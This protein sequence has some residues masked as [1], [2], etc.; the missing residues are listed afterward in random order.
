MIR[1]FRRKDASRNRQTGA[2][3]DG[4]GAENVET[5]YRDEGYRVNFHPG[6]S[7]V[8]I[9]AFGGVGLAMG[10]IQIDEFRNTL[11]GKHNVYFLND[12]KRSWWNN[13][14]IEDV[15]GDVVESGRQ[16]GVTRWSAIGNS[17][18]GSG[19]MLASVLVEDIERVLAYSPQANVHVDF[20]QEIRWMD[21]RRQISAFRWENY[22]RARPGCQ[23]N[24]VFG[25]KDDDCHK[26]VFDTNN[27]SYTTVDKCR[28]DVPAYLKK[29][30][31]KL[32]RSQI[33]WVRF[34]G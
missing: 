1:L 4:Q 27:L 28:H 23:Y 29:K 2:E 11:A 34:E 9:M 25:G 22:A 15:L 8:A 17:M 16:R 7:D 6:E 24:V 20:T 10:G 26:A 3:P 33:E 32:Y 18:G 30:K 19:A 13:G 12:L 21:Y 14:K 5:L 31:N